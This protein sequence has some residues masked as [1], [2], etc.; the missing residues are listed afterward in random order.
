MGEDVVND[1]DF[2][3]PFISLANRLLYFVSAIAVCHRSI[4]PASF[5]RPSVSYM[6]SSLKHGTTIILLK[7]LVA[8]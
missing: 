8:F 5:N 4:S 6:S 7:T 1:Q 3:P 2:G